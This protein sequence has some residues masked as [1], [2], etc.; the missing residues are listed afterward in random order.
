[1]SESDRKK[2]KL[3]TTG[4]VSL[5]LLSACGGG[6]GG[7]S[8]A[9]TPPPTQTQPDPYVP[10]VFEP[11]ER[12]RYLCETPPADLPGTQGTSTDEN[13]WL[14]SWSNELY[15]WYD[16]IVDRNPADFATADYFQLQKTELLT[17]SG[18]PKDRFHFTIGTEEWIALSQSGESAGYGARFELIAAAPPRQVVTAYV[19]AGTPAAAATLSRGTEIVAINGEEVATTSNV[20][21]LNDALFPTSEGLTYAFTVL[22]P[23]AASTRTVNLTSAIVTTDPVNVVSVTDTASGPVGYVSFTDHIATS[24]AELIA[25]VNQLSAAN[26]TDLVLDLRYNSGG[27]LDI[28]N[29]L[30][31]MIA[32]PVATTGQVFD[33]IQ[34]NDKYPDRNPVTNELLEPDLFHTTTQG[35][36]TNPG[37]PLPSLSLNRVFVITSASTCSAS[38]TIVNGLQGI[39]TEVI[40]I[41]TTTCGKPYGFYAFDNCGMSYFSIQFRGVN[42]LGFG[43]YTDGFSPTNVNGIEGVPVPGCE[44]ADDY[45]RQ[46]GDP[47]EQN[48]AVALSYRE[49]D[50]CPVLP[51]AAQSSLRLSKYP[52]D[53]EQVITRPPFPGTVRL[54][55]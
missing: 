38:E 52:G 41:G 26:I 47:D 3:V 10:G 6:G 36:S 29:E 54:P 53:P 1:M 32:G 20:D 27:F 33:E 51:A 24:E 37:Q 16:E 5:I 55:R 19:D 4:M 15:L 42:A 48:F 40:Q 45:T 22:D 21:L 18:A 23:G 39:G 7:G 2:R 43:D 50:L 46:L 31:F 13:N 9:F 28:A 44:V 12:F 8:T 35:F 11:S 25:A 49:T 30:A 17:A 34:F 14:R